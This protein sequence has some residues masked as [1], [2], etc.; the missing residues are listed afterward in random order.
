M[1]DFNGIDNGSPAGGDT[2]SP[3]Q[4]VATPQ[5][6]PVAATLATPQAPAIG[7][8]QDDRSNWVP[9]HRIRET[10]E[11]AI[12]ES[13]A[14]WQQRE[15]QIRAEADQYRTQLHALVGVQPPQNPE[16]DAIKNQF[17]KLYPG[18]AKLEERANDLLGLQDRAG[19]LESQTTHY[20]QSYGKQSLD[21]LFTLA[22]DTMGAPLTD[23]GK[24]ALHTSFLGY[25]QSSP[26]L[27]ERYAND[28]SLVNEFWKAFSSNFIDPVR[29][30]AAA[31]VVGR[32]PGNLP[33]DTPS[34][35]P[36]G[37]PA[38]QMSGLDERA[39]AAWSMFSNRNNT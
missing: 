18:L 17:S 31:G 32:L 6:P 24:Q 10:R 33:Q 15:A 34:G 30:T 14:Q 13:Q 9:P 7:A 16:V 11:A 2:P 28:P 5:A 23:G 12:R 22:S 39:N 1:S 29:R 3:A 4:P 19:D 37:T 36:R 8:P 26:E 35:A 20:W 27:Q 21:R 25:V 38:P